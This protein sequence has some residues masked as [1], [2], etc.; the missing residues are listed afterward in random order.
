MWAGASRY[1]S[2]FKMLF[3]F[4]KK[5]SSPNLTNIPAQILCHWGEVDEKNEADLGHM[6]RLEEAE[7]ELPPSKATKRAIQ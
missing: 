4:S 2:P 1:R 6:I 3:N 7:E 5:D